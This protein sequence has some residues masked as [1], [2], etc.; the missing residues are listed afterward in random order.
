MGAACVP[1][2]KIC[3]PLR[4]GT[5]RGREGELRGAQ[6]GW[7]TAARGRR[8][9]TGLRALAD[10][11]VSLHRPHPG[12]TKIRRDKQGPPHQPLRRHCPTQLGAPRTWTT[13]LATRALPPPWGAGRG[14]GATE[15][16]NPSALEAGRGEAIHLLVIAMLLN[17]LVVAS[18]PGTNQDN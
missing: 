6:W 13:G 2:T 17:Q 12:A 4:T 1:S 11:D 5:R 14:G 10:L 3:A 16:R 8:R 7:T 9:A 15:R 18:R